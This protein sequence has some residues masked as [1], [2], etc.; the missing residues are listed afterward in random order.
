MFIVPES[1]ELNCAKDFLVNP[2]EEPAPR[3][4]SIDLCN[5]LELEAM[6]ALDRIPLDRFEEVLHELMKLFVSSSI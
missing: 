5:N 2:G 1:P 4:P 3:L 6:F